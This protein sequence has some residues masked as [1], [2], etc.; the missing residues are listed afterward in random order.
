MIVI[1]GRVRKNSGGTRQAYYQSQVGTGKRKGDRLLVLG[2]CT[3]RSETSVIST[4][5]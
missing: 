4:G 2:R 3:H 1:I 5:Q